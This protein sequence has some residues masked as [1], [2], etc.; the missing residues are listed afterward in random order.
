MVL[1]AKFYKVVTFAIL[2]F[3]SFKTFA[4]VRNYKPK[5]TTASPTQN[6]NPTKTE[7]TTQSASPTQKTYPAQYATKSVIY[8]KLKIGIT[9]N[10]QA[11]D[12]NDVSMIFVADNTKKGF[13]AGL[14]LQ[15]QIGANTYFLTELLYSQ[16]G[17]RYVLID[18]EIYDFKLNY[19]QVPV[20]IK[21]NIFDFLNFQFGP[22]IGV[23]VNSQSPPPF[24]EYKYKTLDYGIITGLG[25]NIPSAHLGIN[26]RLYFG[27]ANVYSD[28]NFESDSEQNAS[29]SI[30]L[31]Y[32]F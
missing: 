7:N 12:I 27:L 15:K 19:I 6:T 4:Q 2:C 3:I 20:L 10:Y 13:N 16:M 21:T 22:Q 32:N 30:G 5:S 11:T 25:I 1:T 14:T 28:D 9:A 17:L 8:S 24:T 31:S 26:S 18:K 29:F 23:L